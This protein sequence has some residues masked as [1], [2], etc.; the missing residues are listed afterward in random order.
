MAKPIDTDVYEFGK[1][2]MVATRR[3]GIWKPTWW[4]VCP[5][6]QQRHMVRR[7]GRKMWVAHCEKYRQEWTITPRAY[8]HQVDADFRV[9]M[10]EEE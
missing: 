9:I 7:L 1:V 6:C 5:D 8:Y 2:I 10:G 4:L 3:P